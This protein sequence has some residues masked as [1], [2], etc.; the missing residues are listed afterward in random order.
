MTNK[1]MV[2]GYVSALVERLSHADANVR[3]GSSEALGVLMKVLGEPTI[4]KLM[5][6]VDAIKVAKVKEF[7]E[8]AELTGKLPKAEKPAA[9]Q[10]GES[11]GPKKVLTGGAK[12]AAA[13]GSGAKKPGSAPARKTTAPAVKK[14]P[15]REP[16]PE[17][18]PAPKPERKTTAAGKKTSGASKKKDAD[19]DLSPPYVANDLKKTRFR[20][21]QE[22]RKMN[23]VHSGITSK[24]I[25]F[26]T[27]QFICF[28]IVNSLCRDDTLCVA[29]CDSCLCLSSTYISGTKAS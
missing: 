16:S 13:T 23:T 20:Y 29:L 9:P 19:V 14:S 10:G 24:F 22:H 7:M 25:F 17:P 28:A 5:P 27:W 26:E 3:D 6:D 2:K 15:P 8:K 11:G 18:E 4:T 1:K 12:K 21:A